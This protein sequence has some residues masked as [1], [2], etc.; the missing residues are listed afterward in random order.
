MFDAV[1]VCK[2]TGSPLLKILPSLW[3]HLINTKFL[4]GL[5]DIANFNFL[6]ENIFLFIWLTVNLLIIET[7]FTHFWIILLLLIRKLVLLTN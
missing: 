7:I 2:N 4:L 5:I 1:W 3:N 6:L